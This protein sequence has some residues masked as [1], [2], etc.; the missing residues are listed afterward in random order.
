MSIKLQHDSKYAM[1]N[2]T[3]KTW[4]GGVLET[5]STN[6]NKLGRGQGL[7]PAFLKN[8]RVVSAV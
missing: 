7:I 4:G 6:K 3:I 1:F 8:R 5:V 2:L